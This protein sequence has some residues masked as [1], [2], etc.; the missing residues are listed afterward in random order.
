MN[1]P[2]VIISGA[3][4][5]TGAAAAQAFATQGASL[6]L[7]SSN[8]S[9]L[10][11][12][13]SMLALPTERLLAYQADL[14]QAEA[15]Q[16]AGQAVVEKFG[17]ADVL[18][19]LVGGWTGG[20][21]LVETAS[22]DLAQMVNQHLW[23]TFHLIQAFVPSMVANSW[24]RVMLVSS[25]VALQTPP[26][27]GAYAIGKAA[28]ESLL[29]TLAQETQGTGVTANILQVRTIDVNE[30]GKG[31]TPAEIVAAMQYL[32]SDEA[33]RVSGARIPIYN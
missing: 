22:Q 26:K 15:V 1:K 31:S 6:A 30:S 4:G 12:L 11:A 8:S 32:I 28:Q 23:T 18:I 9:K 24:G 25:P 3:T 21:T 20:Q 29:L 2:V 14:R 17:R 5:A 10:E 33:G 16:A 7:L 13:G 27:M 19:Q